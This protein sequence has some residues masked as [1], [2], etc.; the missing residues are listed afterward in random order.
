MVG[1]TEELV[2]SPKDDRATV[3]KGVLDWKRING[4]RNSV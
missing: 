4:V 1:A 2:G 3:D